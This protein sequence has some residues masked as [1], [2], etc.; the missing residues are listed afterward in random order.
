MAMF[1]E[2]E[3]LSS[4]WVS[5]MKV[6]V[7]GGGPIANLAVS[8]QDPMA[9]DPQV[10]SALDRMISE[11]RDSGGRKIFPVETVAN[12]IFP[13]EYFRS[14]G[15]QKHRM[16]GYTKYLESQGTRRRARGSRRGTYFERMINWPG[17]INQ[18]EHVIGR[19]HEARRQNDSSSNKTEIA[20]N[21]PADYDLQVYHPARD[22]VIEGFP[23]LSH[24]SLSLVAGRLNLTSLYRSQYFDTRAYGNLLGLSRLLTFI[25]QE[26]GYPVGELLNVAT[27]AK[28][29]R[30]TGLGVRR[31]ARMLEE[32]EAM[33]L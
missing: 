28:L 2:G 6:L 5:A 21:T 13:I 30:P 7:S 11:H 16:H 17:G 12:T 23:C 25:S 9:E 10:R 20:L 22:R 14:H 15:D 26:S 33:Q 18:I 4:A 31:Q 24:I 32:A 8:V 29:D 27:Y 1:I 3:S 19:L